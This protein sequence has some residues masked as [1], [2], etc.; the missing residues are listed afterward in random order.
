M[1]GG[2]SWACSGVGS[3]VPG[4]AFSAKRVGLSRR[5]GPG[6]ELDGTRGLAGRAVRWERGAL[7][8]AQGDGQE[9]SL[10]RR[11]AARFTMNPC[12]G[13]QTKELPRQASLSSVARCLLEQTT[14]ALPVSKVTGRA[15][16]E[17]LIN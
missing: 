6:P 2:V 11:A 8:S 15:R 14:G 16:D 4:G 7:V 13:G 10:E 12:P 17:R 9:S 3:A 5:P 1:A